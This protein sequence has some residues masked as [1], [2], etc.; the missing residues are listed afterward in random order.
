MLGQWAE[1]RNGR[2]HAA[3]DELPVVE[4]TRCMSLV[5]HLATDELVHPALV[6]DP[7]TRALAKRQLLGQPRL[8]SR[9]HAGFGVERDHGCDASASACSG[10]PTGSS[11]PAGAP[12]AGITA[13][14]G[15][16]STA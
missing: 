9:A 4:R 3:P 2:E 16:T 11:F 6:V 12:G 15:M 8:D 7:H 13:T 1:R 10:A 14:I 5:A